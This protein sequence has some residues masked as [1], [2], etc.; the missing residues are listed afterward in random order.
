MIQESCINIIL[1]TLLPTNNGWLNIGYNN[2]I[3]NAKNNDKN[4]RN[5]GNCL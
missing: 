5:V 2:N 1:N 4:D 3:N